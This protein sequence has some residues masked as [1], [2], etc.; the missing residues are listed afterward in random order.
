M[1]RKEFSLINSK[2]NEFLFASVGEEAN[3]MTLNVMSAF[4]RLGMDPWHEAALLA[5]L[6]KDKAIESLA[7]TIARFSEARWAQADTQAIATRLIA[8]LP[9]NGIIPSRSTAATGPPKPNARMASLLIFLIAS[10]VFFT[11]AAVRHE[12]SES[13]D[14]VATETSAPGHRV[15]VPI[16]GSQK[17]D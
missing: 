16:G 7:P 2:F 8:F 5:D 11:V 12:A 6:P 9:R 14:G 17:P 10:A 15:E 4:S 1:L 3:G 13:D